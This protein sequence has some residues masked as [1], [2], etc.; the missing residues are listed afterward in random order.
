[1]V[2][3]ASMYKMLHEVCIKLSHTYTCT[4]AVSF[5]WSEIRV[6]QLPSD[7]QI[8]FP[9]GVQAL[10][11]TNEKQLYRPRRLPGMAYPFEL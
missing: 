7:L 4:E 1:M 8:A 11:I 10:T 5:W 9:L 2:K 6:W 3:A